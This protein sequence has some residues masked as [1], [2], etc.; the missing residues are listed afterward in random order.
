MAPG[1][2][3]VLCFE[4]THAPGESPAARPSDA[5]LAA[6]VIRQ[7][8]EIGLFRANEVEDQLVHRLPY[9]YPLYALDYD[10]HLAQVFEGLAKIPNL[11]TLGRQGLF[12]HNNMDHSIYMALKAAEAVQVN[13]GDP[14]RATAAWYADVDTFKTLRIVD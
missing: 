1:D 4:I 9:A 8:A 2:R 7:A 13:P 3:T 5:D 10:R 11:I 6:Q 12:N 14:A